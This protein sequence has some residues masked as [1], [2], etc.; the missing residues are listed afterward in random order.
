[1]V[2]R[3]GNQVGFGYT[4]TSSQL[5][6]KLPVPG[7]NPQAP[8]AAANPPSARLV[9]ENEN[10]KSGHAGLWWTLGT[11]VVL[12]LAGFAGHKGWLTEPVKKFMDETVITNANKVWG[13]TKELAGKLKFW[14]E[15]AEKTA[16]GTA[17][18]G[19]AQAAEQT[20]EKGA[21]DAGEKVVKGAEE[22]LGKPKEGVKEFTASVNSVRTRNMGLKQRRVRQSAP[23]TI[24]NTTKI[25]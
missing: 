12:G 2:T 17:E 13:K 23:G 11:V 5:M 9:D 20:V 19:A 16:A 10:K 1:M 7:A 6:Q 4:T 8:Q 15:K 3:I 22:S 21:A 14:G 25:K 18:K 24:I